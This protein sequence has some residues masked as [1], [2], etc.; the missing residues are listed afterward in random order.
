MC[1]SRNCANSSM[2]TS[3]LALSTAMNSF[4]AC[5]SVLLLFPVIKFVMSFRTQ[6]KWS[7][8]PVLHVPGKPP[9]HSLYRVVR[10]PAC[11]AH[12]RDTH[13][14]KSSTGI[15]CSQAMSERADPSFR[16]ARA[17]ATCCLLVK[18]FRA[19]SSETWLRILPTT[20]RVLDSFFQ[21]V[22]VH[23]FSGDPKASSFLIESFVSCFVASMFFRRITCHPSSF[24]TLR[25]LRSDGY[26]R[27]DTNHCVL[28]NNLHR[29]SWCAHF[30]LLR[31]R[32]LVPSPSNDVRSS[33]LH[34]P[35]HDTCRTTSHP[36]WSSKRKTFLRNLVRHTSSVLLRAI[37][38]N[39]FFRKGDICWVILNHPIDVH[40]IHKKSPSLQSAAMVPESSCEQAAPSNTLKR[41][42]SLMPQGT[43][44]LTMQSTSQPSQWSRCWCDECRTC[45]RRTI[46]VL[47]QPNWEFAIHTVEDDDANDTL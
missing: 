15:Q 5:A 9:A 46:G 28:S 37:A 18:I 12:G 41:G 44:A 1:I 13:H 34:M 11:S 27:T 32:F 8:S 45:V 23:G 22:R 20:H 43:S 33:S 40:L 24:M 10:L 47:I 26:D 25:L 42:C 16:F 14:R 35:A 38:I 3:G 36:L 4:M 31:R 17:Y 21:A 29:Y 30:H 7:H 19:S 2:V 6:I 39:M